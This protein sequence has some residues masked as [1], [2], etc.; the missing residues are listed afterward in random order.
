MRR[1]VSWGFLGAKAGFGGFGLRRLVSQG[2]LGAKAPLQPWFAKDT[3]FFSAKAQNLRIRRSRI[4]GLYA[5]FLFYQ[6]PCA[7][8]PEFCKAE[9]WESL[10]VFA[11]ECFSANETGIFFP[12]FS[13]AE[14]GALARGF[15]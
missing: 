1:L 2:F 4:L 14:F 9:F 5:G 10:P 12:E 13:S 11:L 8:A 15:W 6:H 7:K 3:A